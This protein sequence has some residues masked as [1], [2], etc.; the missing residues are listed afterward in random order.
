MAKSVRR[1]QAI[2]ACFAG[3]AKILGSQLGVAI[4]TG[5]G[6]GGD[7]LQIE[8]RISAMR[9]PDGDFV[10]KLPPERAA[11]LIAASEAARSKPRPGG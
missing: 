11:T 6:F 9:A 2:A 8:G 5:K 4:G 10:P 1:A 7:A 3:I